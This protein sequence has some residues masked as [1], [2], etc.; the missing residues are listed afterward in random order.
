MAILDIFSKRQAKRRGEVPDVFRYDTVPQQ[1][2]VQVVHI[3]GD[4]LHG[5]DD[6]Q[7][8]FQQQVQSAYEN[9]CKWLC[10]EY[11]LFRLNGNC[12]RA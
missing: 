4:L 5:G 6:T 12:Q 10:R 8:R 11:G 2:R 3:L 1:L 9:I 7:I